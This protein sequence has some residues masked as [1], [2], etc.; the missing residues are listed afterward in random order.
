MAKGEAVM[1]GAVLIPIASCALETSIEGGVRV[2][3]LLLKPEGGVSTLRL[4]V[5][6]V[7]ERLGTWLKGEPSGKELLDAINALRNRRLVVSLSHRGFGLELRPLEAAPHV[8]SLD[9]RSAPRK[10]PERN[11]ATVVDKSATS[12]LPAKVT[13]VSTD[14]EGCALECDEAALQALLANNVFCVGPWTPGKD[15]PARV[16]IEVRSVTRSG[17]R[18]RV[19]CHVTAGA[20]RLKGLLS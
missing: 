17:N 7:R 12:A 14:G 1:T 19:G 11:D 6:T 3:Y 16:E 9:T 4:S 8:V 20:E 2:E 15:Q 10:R 5:A 18:Y 13:D